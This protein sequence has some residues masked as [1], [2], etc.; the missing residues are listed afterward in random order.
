MKKKLMK[1]LGG[2][3]AVVSLSLAGIGSAWA[4]DIYFISNGNA[5]GQ[6]RT[7]HLACTAEAAAYAPGAKGIAERAG[8]SGSWVCY[9]YGASGGY[10]GSVGISEFGSGC[11]AP[12]FIDPV[13]GYCV[14]PSPDMG[15]VCDSTVQADGFPK[16]INAAGECV[17]VSRADTLAFCKYG[18]TL[19]TKFLKFYISFDSD[20]NPQ[21]PPNPEKLGCKV[22]ILSVANCKLPAPSCANK[23]CGQSMQGSCMVAASYT[24]E[25]A[26]NGASMSIG[27]PQAGTEGVCADGVDCSPPDQPDVKENKQ[28]NYV[29]DGDGRKVCDSRQ[30]SGEPGEMNCGYFNGGSYTCTAK[31]P[32][33]NGIDISTKIDTK[34]NS[35]GSTTSTKTDVATKYD[36]SSGGYS[37]CKVTTTTT[38]TTTTKNSAGEVTG[39]NSQTT[40]KGD[41][42]GGGSSSG[43]GGGNNGKGDDTTNCDPATDP[44]ACEGGSTDGGGKKCDAPIQCDG[45]AVMCAILQQ[46]HKDTCELMAEPS[47]EEKSKLEQDKA[48]EIAKVDSLQKDLDQKASGLFADFKVKASGGQ[49]AGQCL[50]DKEVDIMGTSFTFPF[51]KACPYLYLLRYA[52]IA[53]AYLAAARIVS[54][55][56]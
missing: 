12:A 45:D 41:S 28:C 40:C 5:K 39:S 18:A 33:A 1:L 32:T 51:S 11:T 16:V 44:K 46:Q 24:G 8:G 47:D 31:V 43:G 52:I 22:D 4:V 26:G 25:L 37:N 55:G 3:F 20:G 48:S 54:R 10:V 56:I 42:C 14:D 53:M 7:P 29:L 21:S 36:C 30:F 2:L 13:G 23:F 19:G 27:N 17:M 50:A 6:Y 15:K 49:Y 35:D 34:S 9:L 38:T